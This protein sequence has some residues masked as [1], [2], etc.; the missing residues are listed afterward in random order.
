MERAEK[1]KTKRLGF[2]PEKKVRKQSRKSWNPDKDKIAKAARARVLAEDMAKAKA[3]RAAA[4]RQGGGGDR[5]QQ[6]KM[7]APS[8]AIPVGGPAAIMMVVLMI[9]GC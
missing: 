9:N 2:I 8:R 1:I 5:Q 3:S 6:T 4:N 7:P